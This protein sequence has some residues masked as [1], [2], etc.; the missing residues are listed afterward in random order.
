MNFISH[1]FTAASTPVEVLVSATVLY[2]LVLIV[3]RIFTHPSHP[4]SKAQYFFGFCLS[5]YGVLLGRITGVLLFWEWQYRQTANYN[6]VIFANTT[7]TQLL[8]NILLFIPLG[9]LIPLAFSGPKWNFIKIFFISFLTASLIEV[10]Q[11]F[12]VG[13]VFDINDLLA[14]TSGGIIGYLLFQVFHSFFQ[15]GSRNSSPQNWLSILVNLIAAL[16][17]LPLRR[18][19]MGDLIFA[20]L[21]LPVWSE[22]TANHYALNS[23]HYTLFPALLLAIFSLFLAWS[24]KKDSLRKVALTFSIGNFLAV[25]ALFYLQYKGYL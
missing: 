23:V 9:L 4:L 3:R 13:R 21:H 19:S 5:V 16:W 20:N 2:L 24:G 25:L 11:L 22:N 12:L 7:T 8:L 1:F 15:K 6:F 18:T 10:T 14:N 17:Y